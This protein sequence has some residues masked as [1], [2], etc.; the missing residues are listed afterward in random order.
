MRI[1]LFLL[2][3]LP[4]FAQERALNWKLAAAATFELGADTF[5]QY[6]T[7][8]GITRYRLS[9]GAQGCAEGNIDPP[10][11]SAKRLYLQNYAIDAGLITF[12]YFMRRKHV[13]FIPYAPL[14]TA[15]V[16]HLTGGLRWYSYNCL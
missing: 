14:L 8:Q 3:T 12:G 5:D 15:G 13:P 10:F 2:L 16:K 7:R 4:C 1:V 6:V 9:H 11:P